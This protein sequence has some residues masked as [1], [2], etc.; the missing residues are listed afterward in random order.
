MLNISCFF[1]PITG[2]QFSLTCSYYDILIKPVKHTVSKHSQLHTACWVYLVKVQK[3]TEMQ[4]YIIG[5]ADTQSWQ[6][7]VKAQR[8]VCWYHR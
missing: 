6:K 2:H 1:T 4:E 7:R 3:K 8:K 5:S